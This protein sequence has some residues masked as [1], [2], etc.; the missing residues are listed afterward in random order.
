MTQLEDL[1]LSS[2]DDEGSHFPHAHT[3][4]CAPTLTCAALC[5]LL[6]LT[7]L[8]LFTLPSKLLLPPLL[9]LPLLRSKLMKENSGILYI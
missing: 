8:P 2:R 6:N 3:S 1:L 5:S 9:L 4:T 7:C